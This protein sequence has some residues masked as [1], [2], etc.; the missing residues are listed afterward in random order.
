ML[1]VCGDLHEILLEQVVLLS[2]EPITLYLTRENECH[3]H[4]LFF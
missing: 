3:V 2:C 1:G 4:E